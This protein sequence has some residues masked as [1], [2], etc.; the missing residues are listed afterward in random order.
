[1]AQE[2]VYEIPAEF[3]A[4]AHIN[5]AQYQTMMERTDRRATHQFG[6]AAGY[7]LEG[8]LPPAAHRCP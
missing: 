2:K 1:M 8:Q 6:A 3:A 5:E 4:A 7:K